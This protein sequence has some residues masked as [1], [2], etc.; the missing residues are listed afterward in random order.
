MFLAGAWDGSVPARGGG[1]Y[2]PAT[3]RGY[4]RDLRVRVLPVLGRV[5]LGQ[6]GREDV[7]LLADSW[8]RE[9]ASASTVQNRLDPL[10]AICRRA[11]RRGMLSVDPTEH[12][13]LRAPRGRRDRIAAPG[14]AAELLGFLSGV[15][16]VVFASAMYAGLRRGEL[17]ALRRSD[18]DLAAGVVRVRR[19]WDDEEGEQDGKSEAAARDVPVLAPLRP[20][21]A[22][23]LLGLPAVGDP[24]VFGRSAGV[25]FAKSSLSERARSA[26]ARENRR[27]VAER[28]RSGGPVL[29]VPIGLHEARHTCASTFIAAGANP[30]VV[31]RIMGHATIHMT[32]DRYGH[33]F[34]GDLGEAARAA[35]AFLARAGVE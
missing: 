8:T 18:V 34:P 27:R 22:E 21:L 26:W 31:Q 35:D 10:R 29:L 25:P 7:Q 28:V 24:L 11:L 14:E 6:L 13:E 2:R 23:R 30:K 16:R 1:R 32:F 20:L 4:E 9:G 19:G 17:R 3:L 15:T 12:L 33:L 5:K